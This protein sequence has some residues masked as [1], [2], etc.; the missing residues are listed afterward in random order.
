MQEIYLGIDVSKNTLDVSSSD[1]KFKGKYY[2]KHCGYL[3]LIKD[4]KSLKIELFCLEA[5]GGYEK[6]IVNFLSENAFPF[7]VVLPLKVRQFA[8]SQGMLAKT[9]TLDALIIAKYAKVSAECGKLV[10]QVSKT[11]QEQELESLVDRRTELTQIIAQEKNRSQQTYGSKKVKSSIART[12]K[13][14][15]KEKSLLDEEIKTHIEND[16]QLKEKTELLMTAP[17]VG[18]VTSCV[19]ISKLQELGTLKKGAI[20]ALSGVAPFNR[21]SGSSIRGV[22]SVKGGRVSVRNALFMA[23]LSAVRSKKHAKF[24]DFFKKLVA[25]G[26]KPKVAI[27]AV[28]R[29]IIITLNAMI[30]NNLEFGKFKIQ[31]ASDTV[32]TTIA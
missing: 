26:K 31:N 6:P 2:N 21:E 20:S 3:K 22:R 14:L 23:A 16:K 27:V 32:A 10:A 4:L 28:M 15:E 12:I 13:M 24:A 1:G 11:P 18:F 17:G 5:T 8:L 30:K 25:K 7:A 19:L 9:D 29:K